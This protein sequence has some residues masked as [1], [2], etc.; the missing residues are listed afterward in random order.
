MSTV[1]IPSLSFLINENILGKCFRISQQSVFYGIEVVLYYTILA[2][3]GIPFIKNS[4]W[5]E[6]PG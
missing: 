3:V 1:S 5:V 2:V 6:A 4:N